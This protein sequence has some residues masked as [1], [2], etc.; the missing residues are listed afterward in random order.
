EGAA[1]ADINRD[2]RID[3]VSGPFWYQGPDF[4]ERHE[5]Y[6]ATASF[7]RTRDDA[8]T[9]T[10]PGYEGALGSANAHSDNFLVFI[11]DFDSDSWPDILIAPHPGEPAYWYE[12]PRTQDQHWPRHMLVDEAGNESPAFVDITGDGRPEFFVN[13]DGFFGYAEQTS[14]DPTQP[15]T[16]RPIT[17][18][19]EWQRYT[20]GLGVGDVNGDGLADLVEADGWWEQPVPATSGGGLQASL[21]LRSG[22]AGGTAP[23]WTLHPAD[24]GDGAQ[25]HVYDV[26][27]DGLADVVGSLD[28]HGYGLAWHEQVRDGD[29]ITFTRHLIMGS[30]PGETA[31]GV[32]FSQL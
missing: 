3:I 16:F 28:A 18:Q 13:A 21:G 10:I 19:G 8:S 12:N 5:Y 17:P 2:G 1:A 32:S 15:W 31:S 24:F 6:P 11:Y 25:F 20:H 22:Q 29:T 26:N 30:T 27:D 4:T 14:D 9:V 7:E 23:V